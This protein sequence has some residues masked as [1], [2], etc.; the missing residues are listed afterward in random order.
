MRRGAE[1]MVRVATRRWLRSAR[2]RTPGC[3]TAL[4]VLAL[5]LPA[6]TAS[7]QSAKDRELLLKAAFLYNFAKFVE[8]PAAAFASS[9]AP[10]TMCIH[11]REA[12]AV[13]VE[14]MDGKTVGN[15]PL[16]V[17]DGH[18]PAA[19]G[20]CHITFIGAD[21]PESSYAQH[22]AKSPHALTVGDRDRFARTGGMVGLVTVDNKIRFEVNLRSSRAAGLR[23]QAA[24]L[25]L[26]TDVI[27]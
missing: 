7:A 8:W 2:R 18:G 5:T 27:E 26:A 17:V 6:G 10:L 13:V 11:S 22:L 16:S 4:L 25:R 24:L 9:G 20:P 19:T 21:E 1:T 3:I 23:I 15:R 12:L 14:A